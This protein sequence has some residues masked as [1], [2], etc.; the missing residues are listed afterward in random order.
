MGAHAF[1]GGDGESFF[2]LEH[3]CF[4]PGARGLGPRIF[5]DSGEF[6]DWSPF[7]PKPLRTAGRTPESNH[8]A[9]EC[10][11]VR[12]GVSGCGHTAQNVAGTK[13][14]IQEAGPVTFS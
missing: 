3:G 1:H 14:T 9:E 2:D 6:P 5:H 7:F 13:I 8:R 12:T 4:A 11:R 10:T